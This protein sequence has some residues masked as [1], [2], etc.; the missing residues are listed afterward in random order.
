LHVVAAAHSADPTPRN[1]FPLIQPITLDEQPPVNVSSEAVL[2][3]ANTEPVNRQHDSGASS[4][5]SDSTSDA[6]SEEDLTHV[7]PR[8]REAKPSVEVHVEPA[9]APAPAPSPSPSRSR[10]LVPP[11]S[12]NQ[13]PPRPLDSESSDLDNADIA[14][15]K[16]TAPRQF[17]RAAEREQRQLIRQRNRRNAKMHSSPSKTRSERSDTETTFTTHTNSSTTK[18]SPRSSLANAGPVSAAASFLAAQAHESPALSASLTAAAIK[19]EIA[20]LHNEWREITDQP[21]LIRCAICHF[22]LQCVE[23]LI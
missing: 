3:L 23:C 21:L 16:L 15:S 6:E 1:R 14:D 12:L 17:E 2:N 8:V 7:S 19:D 20:E 18:V 13:L 11:I 9:D 5:L 4:D 22:R 10:G